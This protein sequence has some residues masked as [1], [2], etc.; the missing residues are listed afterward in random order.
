MLCEVGQSQKEEHRTV[1]LAQGTESGGF[2]GLRG[3]SIQKENYNK[4]SFTDLNQF[5]L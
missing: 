5:Y 1:P 3:W 4:S 2:Q